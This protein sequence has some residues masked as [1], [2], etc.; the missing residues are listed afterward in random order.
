MENINVVKNPIVSGTKLY[1]YE[2]EII[3]DETLFKKLVGS[4]VYLTTTRHN[5]T[6][7]ISLISRF[8]TSS[9]MSHWL[10]TKRI[11]RY[12]KRTTNHVIFYT[13]KGITT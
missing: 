13:K 6:C 4:L 12:L 5:L 11:L 8:M 3:A 7:G 2:D 1:N 10:S 9:T